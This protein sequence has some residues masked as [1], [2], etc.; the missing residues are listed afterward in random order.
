RPAAA[1]HLKV[2]GHYGISSL[3]RKY[4]D[5]ASVYCYT[6]TRQD[7]R[8]LQAGEAR[9]AL[10]RAQVASRVTGEERAVSFGV[11]PLGQHNLSG[12]VREAQGDEAYG[13]M[14]DEV[15]AAFASGEL[16]EVVHLF[17][18]HFGIS[19]YSLRSLFKDEQ[20]SIIDEILRSSVEE[21]E[22]AYRQ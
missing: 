5:Q 21:A 7:Y 17:D 20:R 18:E 8:T 1:D 19:S 22:S 9:L 14:A 11:L 4:D 12:G 13:A 2:G 3:F 16:S 6:V 10:G 15:G